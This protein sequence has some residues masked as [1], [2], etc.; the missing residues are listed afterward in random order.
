MATVTTMTGNRRRPR[1]TDAGFT[2][3][4]TLIAIPILAMGLLT[5][6]A[7]LSSGLTRISA[8]GN[9][10]VAKE[11]A[12]EAIEGVFMARDTGVVSWDQIRNVT[13]PGPAGIFLDGPQPLRTAGA[14]GLINTGDDGPVEKVVT[15][16]LDDLIDTGDDVIETLDAYT[17]EIAITDLSTH[18]R[19]VRIVVT[20]PS[21]GVLREYVI[22]TYI[23]AFA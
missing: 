5:V 18:L 2:L 10:A 8:S 21:N 22:S 16:G 3:M 13:S 1:Q 17:R 7:I 6:A 4:E 19:E 9:Y 23:S 15:P 12:A 11:K 20:Y 14:D